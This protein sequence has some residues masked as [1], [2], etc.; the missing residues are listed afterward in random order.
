[1]RETM[2]WYS[3]FYSADERTPDLVTKLTHDQIRAYDEQLQ[4]RL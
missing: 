1:M 2:S 3:A 4:L